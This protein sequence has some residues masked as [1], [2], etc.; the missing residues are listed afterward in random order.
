MII[1]LQ[2]LFL[3][4]L[5]KGTLLLFFNDCVKIN[6]FF[7]L[8]SPANA[9]SRHF[10]DEEHAECV[11]KGLSRREVIRVSFNVI[12]TELPIFS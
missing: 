3:D 12:V 2:K 6:K 1:V 9:P 4:Q 5:I 8:Y 11:Q 7:L 10:K